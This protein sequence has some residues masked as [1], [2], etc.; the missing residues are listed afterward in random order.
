M[1]NQ[2]NLRKF[3]CVSCQKDFTTGKALNK[4]FESS[5]K[6]D[7]EDPGKFFV[8]KKC[9]RSFISLHNFN[10]HIK[11]HELIDDKTCPYCHKTFK[12]LKDHIKNV[13]R[14]RQFICGFEGCN[15]NFS[16]KN[17]LDR[18]LKTHSDDF[19]P[20]QCPTCS[21]M[22]V[23]KI[24]LERHFQVHLK[25]EKVTNFRCSQC[26]KYFNRKPDL[27]RHNKTV[28]QEKSYEC[29]LCPVRRFGSKFDVLRHFKTVHWGEK[30]KR[31]KPAPK[32]PIKDILLSNF[33]TKE[34]LSLNSP[35]FESSEE[36]LEES[37]DE[38]MEIFIRTD[39]P[40]NP[41]TILESVEPVK[42]TNAQEESIEYFVEQL[43]EEPETTEI[44]VEP[45]QK[46][47]TQHYS[48][49]IFQWDCQRC[50]RT[51][52]SCDRLKLHNKRNHSWTCNLC[53]RGQDIINM[54]HRKVDFELHWM[55]NHE[56]ETFP[57]KTECTICDDLFANVSAMHTHQRNEHGI[58]AVK[59]IR[60]EENA[61][62]TCH[63]C[64]EELKSLT[65][66]KKHLIQVHSERKLRKCYSCNLQFQLFIDFKNHVESHGH[67]YVCLVCGG[68]PFEDTKALRTHQIAS[69][70]RCPEM[71]PWKC[72]LCDR[73]FHCKSLITAHMTEVHLT[74]D[75]K[76]ICDICGTIYAELHSLR[77]HKINAHR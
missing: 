71:K 77:I 32:V 34:T 75:D 16:K 54:F 4:H 30:V 3:Y 13:H 25:T 42:S 6:I 61:A 19:K 50:N 76:N 64:H 33:V 65:S 31:K 21:R 46:V 48:S 1:D 47:K 35:H 49:K 10:Q 24:Q 11:A 59:R 45:M 44:W 37:L 63:H 67:V 5:H 70:Y 20:Y 26:M 36:T 72:D 66:L 69:H 29:D 43:D 18:H 23:E 60:K 74:S 7:N 14:E 8:C 52:E 28:H 58:E 9:D 68:M 27:V 62:R 41:I 40:K 73:N 56:H 2:V 17:G 53:P 15:K 57:N 55:E 12:A 22:F 51:Y 39:Q 38:P